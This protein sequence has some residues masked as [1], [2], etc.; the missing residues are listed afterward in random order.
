VIKSRAAAIVLATV[1][2]AAAA[3]GGSSDKKS[4]DASAS[5]SFNAVL[6]KNA[7]VTISIDC[8]PAA[9]KPVESKQWSDDIAAFHQIYPNV[10][11]NSKPMSKCEDPAPFTAQ[12]RGHTETDVFYTY[13]TDK[14]QVLD[15]GE[16]ADITKYVTP[17]TVTALKDIQPAILDINRDNGKLYALPRTNYTMGLVYDRALFK[18]AGLNPDQPP[19]TWADIAT[20]A[21]AIAKLGGGVNGYADYSANNVGGWHF[22][23][24]LYGLGGRMVSQDGTKAAFNTD[25]GKQVLQNLYDMRWKTGGIGST[26]MIK[27]GDPQAAMAAGKLGMFIGAPD[28]ITYMVQTLKGKAANFGMAPMPGGQGT[29][30]GGDDYYF[31]KTDTP[32]QIKAGIAWLNFKLLT[33]GKGQFQ[34]DRNKTGGLPVGLPEPEF[35][36]QG[37]AS[38]KADD[39]NKLASATLPVANFQPF[40]SA[41][42]TPVVEPP[43]AQ[44]IYKVLDNA[45]S[46]VL[47]DKNADIAKL[48]SKAETDVNTVLANQ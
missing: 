8:A 40:L 11:I 38:Q 15:S 43:A 30:I 1:A 20:D 41:S 6:D 25:Q 28:D 4:G 26:Q 36:V 31:K 45:M 14:A 32:D 23:A 3:C 37:S 34:Y 21:A 16:A 24:E 9:N 10:T 46:A 22:T 35:F 7:K 19:T 44:E 17:Q 48:L 47:T 2:V 18:K 27:W 29:L 12:L 39:A 13:F 5:P 33:P 42:P